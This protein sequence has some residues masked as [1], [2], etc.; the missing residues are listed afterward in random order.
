MSPG[1]SDDLQQI[2][3]CRKTAVI[4]SELR[5]LNIDIAALQETRLAAD[6]MLRENDYTFFWQGRSIEEPR[7]HGVGFAV[8]NSLLP[9][10]VPPTGGSERI[11]SLCLST[12]SGM[13]NVISAYAPTLCSPQEMKDQFYEDLDNIINKIP[14]TEH[15]ILLGDFNAR[16]GAEHSS[17]PDCLGHFGVGKMNDNGQRLLELCSFRKLCITNTFFNTKPQHKVS[18]RHPR[19]GHWHQLDMIITRRAVLNSVLVTR[20]YQSADCDTDHSLVCSKL[21]LLPKKIHHTK[22]KGRPRINT[23]RASNPESRTKLVTQL[24]DALEDNT[25]PTLEEKWQLIRNAVYNTAIQVWGKKERRNQDWFETHQAEMEPAITAKRETLIAYKKDPSIKNLAALRTARNNT[26][27]I[28]RRCAN[29]Y[30]QNLCQTIQTCADRGNIHGMYEG[31]KKAFGPTISKIAPLKS[32]DGEVISDRA[33]Q[34]ERWAEHYQDLYST[35]TIVTE[36]AVNNIPPMPVMEELDLPPSVEE[37]SKAID[38][39]AHGKA[40]GS[41]GIPAEVIQCGKPALLNHLHELLCQCWE[42]GTVPQDMRDA[43]IVTLYKNKGD[44]SDCNNYRGISLLSIIGKAFAKVVLKRLQ[45]LAERVYPESQCGFRAERST[46]DMIFSLR[47]L[48]EKS[49]EQKQ[50][51]Y[52]AFIDLTKAFDLVSR[53]GLFTLL[54]RI[55]CPPKLLSMVTS[56]HEDMQGTVNVDGSSSAPFPIRSSVKQGC[57]LAPTLFGIFFSLVLS[58]AFRESDDGV[59]LHTRSD[60]KLFNLARLRAK[61]K[62]RRILIQEMLFADDAALASHIQSGLQRQIDRMAHACRE[63]GLTISLKKTEIMGQ[64]VSEAPIINIGDYTLQVVEQFTYLGSTVT[65]NLSLD[66]ELNKRIGKAAAAMSKLTKRV[67]ENNK[68]TTVT[69]V[70]VYR[71]CVLSTLLYGSES[72]TTYSRQEHRLNSFHLRC[73]RRI[74]GITWQD[75]VTNAEVLDRAKLPSM[76]TLLSQRRLRWLGHVHRMKD[77]RIPKD[78]FYG[79]LAAGSRP[80][81]RPTL[82]YKD[83]CKRDLKSADI[84][85]DKWEE[86]AADRDAWRS[87]VRAGLN[88]A[89]G[90]RLQLWSDRRE[91]R[92]AKTMT[93]QPQSSDFQCRKCAKDC[94]SRI[95]LFSHSRRCSPSN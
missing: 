24:Q 40:P 61:T 92:K 5:R 85:V 35:E 27:R 34:M 6:G 79:E 75:R 55:G 9:M 21:R 17:W 82:R 84:S 80:K 58:Y 46:T 86:V 43:N 29:D 59:Y 69:K 22:Q 62:V 4:D 3:D 72:W 36:Q 54:E 50:P 16:V 13:V 91:C 64:D 26:Q 95:G 93:Y 31:M 57:V 53:K 63:F 33:K 70:A 76:F 11:L 45:A 89:E 94:H 18:W 14:E 12:S 23:T 51:L 44:R 81:G 15:I 42:E 20:S 74:L 1:L 78:M 52:I 2:N 67:W 37:L 28:A 87:T 25:A 83:V 66:P 71:A 90:K 10:I 8:K 38:S 7:L 49:R 60:G 73:L 39:L 77:G 41:D 88:T 56:F 30:W 65:S 19:S 68:L 47:Q 32:K 48:Q